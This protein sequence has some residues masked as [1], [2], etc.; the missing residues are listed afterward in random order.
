MQAAAQ[1]ATTLTP[2]TMEPFPKRNGVDWLTRNGRQQLEVDAEHAIGWFGPSVARDEHEHVL[3]SSRA[4]ETVVERAA[5]QACFD[6]L[7][8]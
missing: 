5:G 1:C 2:A 4:D 7:P 3:A 8:Q 6:K